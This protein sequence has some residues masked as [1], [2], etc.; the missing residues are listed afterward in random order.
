M[1]T[2]LKKILNKPFPA[3]TRNFPDNAFYK[4]ISHHIL[5][6]S[7]YL[8]TLPGAGKTSIALGIISE[9]IS[10]KIVWY[11]APPVSVNPYQIFRIKS[12]LNNVDLTV[13]TENEKNKSDCRMVVWSS[14]IF[15]NYLADLD[16]LTRPDLIIFDD[17]EFLGH[18][19][20]GT[21]LETCLLGL[22]EAV[23]VLVLASS[24]ANSKKLSA[25]MEAVCKRSCRLLEINIPQV[26]IIPAFISSKWDTVPLVDRKRLSGKVKRLLKE[27]SGFNN[28]KGTSFIKQLVSFIR[29]ENLTPAIVLMPSEK[30]CDLAVNAC[31]KIISNV[32]EVLTQ[33]QITT[34]LDRYPFLKDYPMLTAALAKQIAP[35]H[36]NHHPLWCTLVEHFLSFGSIDI[37]FVTL[38]SVEKMINR[39]KT[40]VLCIEQK[41]VE[42]KKAYKINQWKMG[43]IANIVGRTETDTAGCI[44]LVHTPDVD[45]VRIKDMLLHTNGSLNS[46]FQCNCRSVLGILANGLEPAAI[47]DRLLF[48]FQNKSFEE[49]DME[50]FQAQLVE[51][52]PDAR[53]ITH[54]KS[55]TSLKDLYLK[56]TLEIS[57]LANRIKTT[58][59]SGKSQNLDERQHKLECRLSQFPCNEC[60]HLSL[61]H[62]RGTKKFRILIE[63]YYEI[64]S[65]LEK[66][67]TGFMIDFQYYVE[68]LQE[69]GLV[70]QQHHLTKE[71]VLALRTGLNFPQSLIECIREG[72]LPVDTS[73]ASF[74]LIGG[75]A[76]CSEYPEWDD[77]TITENIQEQFSELLPGFKKMAT[78]LDRTKKRMLRFGILSPKYSLFQSA[79][80]LAWKKK[81]DIEI[82]NRQTGV[83]TG[84]IVKLIQ[85]TEYL[86]ERLKYSDH[87][88]LKNNFTF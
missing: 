82:L 32:G 74:V 55:V 4:D 18:P 45:A 47:I 61:C 31:S 65:R 70:N 84:L 13:M 76:E 43:R 67:I 24:A 71:G 52:L 23:P 40:A 41:I 12:A 39:V 1:D 48:K 49:L 17:A 79:I 83:P 27:K 34:V 54:I 20:K 36:S 75:F 59:I 63:K 35:F 87:G 60:V 5:A 88:S 8:I 44:A 66:S 62:K 11:I 80:M 77:F 33:P 42:N 46:T 53:C 68:C 3:P 85:K 81:T 15:M 73:A 26:P 19:D 9:I 28:F 86:S 6:D 29:A 72:L 37:V 78:V 50:E 69:F 30:D 21:V 56:L 7:N 2:K 14:D 64:Q 51:E 57:S 16:S 10:H 22:P 38:D 58:N 25:W